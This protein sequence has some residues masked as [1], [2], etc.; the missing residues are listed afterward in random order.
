MIM[1]TKTDSTTPH[2][3]SGTLVQTIQV[4]EERQNF[5]VTEVFGKRVQISVRVKLAP[6]Y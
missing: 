5:A 1:E 2:G 3:V 4:T 6:S